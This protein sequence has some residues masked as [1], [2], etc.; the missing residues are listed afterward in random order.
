MYVVDLE[1]SYEDD[2]TFLSTQSEN[3]DLWHRRLGHVNSSLLN[4]LVS[5]DLVHGL[6]KLKFSESKVGDACVKGKQ[7]RSS[8]K[9]KKQSELFKDF[10]NITH[11]F[12]WASE[13]LKQ[14][15]K[16]VHSGDWR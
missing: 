16:E 9:S 8:F 6:P 5:K 15:W 12:V 4:K 3:A 1:T 7:T 13:G 11:G 2:L 10:G 14:M